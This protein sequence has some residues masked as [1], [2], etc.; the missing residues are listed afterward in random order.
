[1]L[2]NSI[3]LALALLAVGCGQPEMQSLTVTTFEDQPKTF[4]AVVK[5]TSNMNGPTLKVVPVAPTQGTL[6][7][8]LLSQ[9][10]TNGD[11]ATYIGTAPLTPQF[12]GLSYGTHWNATADVAYSVLWQQNHSTKSVD[13]VI[14]DPR[15]CSSFDGAR[16]Y[17][18]W[19]TSARLTSSR[20]GRQ[21]ES[22]LVNW[23][24]TENAR[25]SAA[26]GALSITIPSLP[27]PI[28]GEYWSAHINGGHLTNE[29]QGATGLR[30]A[31]KT[32]GIIS[33]HTSLLINRG[34]P[35][36][37]PPS[38]AISEWIYTNNRQE[39]VGDWRVVDMQFPAF[40]SPVGSTP[41]SYV[42]AYDITFVNVSHGMTISI[43]DVCPTH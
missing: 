28:G 3:Y 7:E 34:V 8:I 24:A 27:S 14:G 6:P 13:F 30:I 20:E 5:T 39:E 41:N 43:D 1:M 36:G 19:S 40:P 10:S 35:S 26:P 21:N 11:I 15:G 23:V 9:S 2:K 42:W 29:W 25:P 31:L 16:T 38:G 37:S 12:A 33:I 17:E 18:G 32:S 4:T 22:T